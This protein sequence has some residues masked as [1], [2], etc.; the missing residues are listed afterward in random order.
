MSFKV[1]KAAIRARVS[2]HAPNAFSDLF[3]VLAGAERDFRQGRSCRSSSSDRHPRPIRRSSFPPVYTMKNLCK[4]HRGMSIDC[5]LHGTGI[6]H[7]NQPFDLAIGEDLKAQAE[8]SDK[9]VDSLPTLGDVGRS[10]GGQF[11]QNDPKEVGKAIDRNTPGMHLSF[12]TTKSSESTC[13][14]SFVWQRTE[15]LFCIGHMQNNK[16]QLCCRCGPD[17]PQEGCG[18]GSRQDQRGHT[19]PERQPPR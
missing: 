14:P 8:A 12:T 1:V 6:A 10:L 16:D 4:L 18:Q 17:R 7:A 15:E 9:K 19:Q 5:H 3:V 11:G 2:G 13:S